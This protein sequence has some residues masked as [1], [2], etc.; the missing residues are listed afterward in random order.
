MSLLLS[1]PHDVVNAKL[2]RIVPEIAA[3]QYGK[4]PMEG[5]RWLRLTELSP[6]GNP[7]YIKGPD[8]GP[9]TNYAHG[10]ASFG[11]AYYH[12]LTKPAY[13]VLYNRTKAD[14]P[15]SPCPCFQSAPA[16]QE[17]KDYDDVLEILLLRAKASIANDAQAVKDTL[18]DAQH[19]TQDQYV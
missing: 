10:I 19:S 14:A 15:F 17:M 1:Q 16:R 6:E 3:S 8:V 11:E 18:L 7:T 9:K 4:Y 2:E 12:L 13:T 5:T